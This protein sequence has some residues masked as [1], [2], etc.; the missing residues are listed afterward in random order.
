MKKTL[1]SL[2]L[3]VVILNSC[4]NSNSRVPS[5]WIVKQQQASAA[6]IKENLEINLPDW[7]EE[8]RWIDNSK[9]TLYSEGAIKSVE[10]WYNGKNPYE[11]L[12]EK[13]K[14]YFTIKNNNG[15]IV[16]TKKTESWPKHVI[17]IYIPKQTNPKDA[18]IYYKIFS[19]T[20][21]QE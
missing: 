6:V 5:S 7:S 19:W 15:F 16:L 2:A 4:E 9:Y 13:R 1:L 21:V 14:E 10:H 18:L 11:N 20:E 12:I 8:E 3:G 17:G